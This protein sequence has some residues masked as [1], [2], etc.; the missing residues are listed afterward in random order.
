VIGGLIL[1]NDAWDKIAHKVHAGDFY[2]TKN[3]T[4]FAAMAEL[5]EKASPFDVVTLSDVMGKAGT[6]EA[7]GGLAYLSEVA[8]NTPHIANINA[9]ADIV[10]ERAV[11]RKLLSATYDI[12]E[13]VYQPDGA[14]GADILDIA[15]QKIFA[16]AEQG[17]QDGGA[18]AIKDVVP[19]VIEVLDKLKDN[20]GG[21][22]GLTTHFTDLDKIT[23]GLQPADVIIVAG[24]PSMGKTL[25]GMNIAE[26]VAMDS[27]KPV[28]F[29]SMEMPKEAIV[30]RALSSLG[31]VDQSNLR[32]GQMSESDWSKVFSTMSLITERMNMYIDDTPSLSP[33]DMRARA[34][35][36]AREHGGLSMV[37][38][39][40]LQLMQ[41]PGGRE[42]RT[43]EV[44]EISRNIKAMA[45]ELNVP[46]IALS[47]LSRKPEERTDKRPMA[48]DLR[49]S[50][51]IE[52]D[53][54]IIAFIYRDEVYNPD[55][56][57]KGI[58]EILIS[59]HRNGPTGKIRLTFLG[60]HC[61][62]DNYLPERI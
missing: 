39:D 19:G 43:V 12:A 45:K 28:L 4:I 35:R 3:R 37:V 54:D 14:S 17:A 27:D 9:Y 30:M 20:P 49:E 18:F 41:I 5:I 32:S 38:L 23:S 22:T 44:S 24:R 56:E 62:F 16:I 2:Q 25:L 34:R 57:D 36:L 21:I 51:S 61:R 10:H 53:A 6:L 1:D 59:K 58:A 29:F 15:E 31:R 46:V 48:S 42:S 50:G 11:M 26:N 55:T 47:Q 13:K 7:A 60:H 52:Q 8:N 33:A 40:Y